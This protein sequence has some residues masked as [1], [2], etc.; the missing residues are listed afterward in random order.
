MLLAGGVSA[1]FGP[2]STAELYDPSTDTITPTANMN[3]A[4]SG[5][6]A[7]LLTDGTVL[8]AGG[9][10]YFSLIDVELYNPATGTISYTG[11]MTIPRA[12]HSA[13][14]LFDG[15]VLTSGGVNGG[16]SWL[17]SAELYT[18]Q[19]LAPAPALFSVSGDGAGQGAIWHADT[20]KIAS[21]AN[22]AAAGSVLSMYTSSLF[23]GGVIP[24]Q[25]AIGGQ[26]R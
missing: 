12:G 14:L 8:V 2:F 10:Y 4:R 1:D 26:A 22:P 5:H 16:G 15:R 24:P 17:N 13:A 25:V 19:L 18:P 7:T 3:I 6:T 11:H 23:E 9:Q 21:S 20:G